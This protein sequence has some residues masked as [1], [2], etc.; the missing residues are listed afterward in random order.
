MQ[1]PLNLKT[2]LYILVPSLS[3]LLLACG[4]GGSTQVTTSL[5]QQPSA[6]G[7]SGT[8]NSSGGNSGGTGT[9]NP[10][11]GALITDV[12][13]E[14]E[15]TSEQSSVPVTFGQVFREGDIKATESVNGR[16]VDGTSLPLQVDVKATHRDGSLRH[17]VISAIL[18]KLE[19]GKV[20]KLSLLRATASSTAQAA[21][22]TNLT[23]KGFTAS[24]N[25]IIGGQTY[26]AS[27]DAL[28]LKPDR[29]SIWLAG[30]LATEWLVW[31]PLTTADGVKHPHLAARFAI[32]SYEGLNKARVDVVIENNWAYEPGPQNFTY[33]VNVLVGGQSAYSK[34]GLTHFRQSR[35]RKTFWWG[36]APQVH[37]K[38]DIPY[39]IASKAVPNYDTSFSISA[40]GLGKLDQDWAAANKEPMAPGGI[41]TYMPATGGRPDIAPLPKWAAM[42]LLS[43]DRRA[44][45]VT[46]GVG[47]LAG[48]WPIHYRDKNTGQIVS[49]LDYPYITLPF[50][51][52]ESDA[53]NKETGLSELVPSCGGD[54]T[55]T[56]FNYNPDSAHQPSL[57]YLPYLVTGDN[58]YMEELQFWA[59]WNMLR[60]NPYYREFGKGLVNWAQVRGQAWTLRTLGQA[61]Y[62]TPDDHPMKAYFLGRLKHNIDWYNS[63]YVQG[64]PNKLGVLDGTG[65]YAFRAIA[66]KTPSGASTGV[67]PWQ[68]DFFTWSVGYLDELGFTDAKPLLQ[69]K[70]KFPVGRM[71]A[72][73]YCWIAGAAYALSVRPSS[74][75]PLFNT[76]EEAY[77][78]TMR[79]EDGSP[80]IN[81]TGA[82]YL[83][84]PC[85]S[86]AQ[87]DWFTQRDKDT[88]TPRSPWLAGEM[89]GYA[90][91]SE[92]F[93]SNMQP[94]LAVAATS[95]IPNADTAWS[96]FMNRSIKPNYSDAPQWAIVPRK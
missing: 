71:T 58:Y 23:N 19:V 85:G 27:A 38:H 60:G 15:G 75:S 4:G 50:R 67:A 41:V 61:A 47:D 21:L 34:A 74:T 29:R 53:M 70:A 25:I 69:W 12:N 54:C 63:V 89:T 81:T 33:D 3:I 8:G 79:S 37:V 48:S 43:M 91:S 30:P 88:S 68:D 62:I 40:T 10:R 2:V 59:N 57:A 24:V 46:L 72:P 80:L 36:Q 73:G 90:A 49:L 22:P 18:P 76:L 1:K 9:T 5:G 52:S 65:Q 64:K 96:I 13:F 77:L 83:A 17:A 51:G 94:A 78:A 28:L 84:Q 82:H 11:L 86:Q 35:W 7:A 56:P 32:R 95:G 93:P 44:K 45:K 66:Y 31:A 20:Q 16:L 26:S 39:L 6:G 42:Y 55:T 14:N 92:G 87:A